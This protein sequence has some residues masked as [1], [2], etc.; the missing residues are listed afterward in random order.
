MGLTLKSQIFS[1]RFEDFS[2]K[3]RRFFYELLKIFSVRIAD[4]L[5]L[6]DL[7]TSEL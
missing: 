6:C 2:N 5:Y 7:K 3:N 1:L 4:F